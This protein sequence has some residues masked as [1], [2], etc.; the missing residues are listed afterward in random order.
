MKLIV[1]IPR[2]QTEDI[3]SL[4]VNVK[5]Y[6]QD[7]LGALK[8]ECLEMVA[9]VLGSRIFQIS[10][11]RSFASGD[12]SFV[13]NDLFSPIVEKLLLLTP[14]NRKGALRSC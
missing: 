9:L 1:W 3:G 7:K 6:S 8:A 5:S 14:Q 13:N 4:P 11:E 10:V 12:L 2:D